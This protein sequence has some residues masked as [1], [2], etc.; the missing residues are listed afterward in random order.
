MIYISGVFAY[1][2][3]FQFRNFSSPGTF[4]IDLVITSDDGV[5]V[6]TDAE[7]QINRLAAN[8]V[9]SYPQGAADISWTIVLTPLALGENSNFVLLTGVLEPSDPGPPPGWLPAAILIQVDLTWQGI[10]TAAAPA[11]PNTGF[12]T[13]VGAL[14]VEGGTRPAE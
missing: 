4:L 11:V 8:V 10:I 5:P 12:A 7:D 13:S 9:L 2:L 14:P 6:F 3:P 1:Q